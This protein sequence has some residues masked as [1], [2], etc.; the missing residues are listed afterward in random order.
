M[1]A[2]AE[3]VKRSNHWFL[4]S[5]NSHGN[6]VVDSCQNN[7]HDALENILNKQ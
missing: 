2:A 4:V 7:V 6:V 1:C 3:F 5:H